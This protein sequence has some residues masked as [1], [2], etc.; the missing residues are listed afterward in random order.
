MPN[1]FPAE[2]REE[3]TKFQRKLSIKSYV[4]FWGKTVKFYC[5]IGESRS[6]RTVLFMHR[7]EL[8]TVQ[9][10]NRVLQRTRGS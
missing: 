8:Q 3:I 6:R 4:K 9:T 7:N 2:E 5:K 10:T 1:S